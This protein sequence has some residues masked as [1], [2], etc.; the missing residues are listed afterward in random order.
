MIIKIIIRLT[1]VLCIIGGIGNIISG[2]SHFKGVYSYGDM[3]IIQGIGS[4][5]IGLYL[6]YVS[7]RS[8]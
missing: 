6:A 1:S 4:I 3:A 8:K 5:I 7:F 2:E